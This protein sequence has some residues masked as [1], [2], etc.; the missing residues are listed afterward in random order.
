MLQNDQRQR[1]AHQQCVAALQSLKHPEDLCIDY[2]Y[3]GRMRNALE[4]AILGL[5]PS[6]TPLE[7]D[8]QGAKMMA[9]RASTVSGGI[10]L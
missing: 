10:I 3:Y 5:A 6:Q 7:R 9:G 4:G 8:S 2:V 1:D